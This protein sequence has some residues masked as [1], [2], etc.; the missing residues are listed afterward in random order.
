MSDALEPFTIA[1]PD[2]DLADLVERLERTRWPE[3][4]PVDDWSQG[5]PLDYMREVCA[6]WADTFDWRAVEAGLNAHP[7]FRTVIDGLG[8][9]VQHIRSPHENALP[10]VITHGWPGSI[11]E[12]QKIIGPLVDPTAHGGDAA[13]A[14]HVVLPSLPGYGW[15]DKPTTTG[16][17]VERIASAW[18]ELMTRLGYE[19]WVAQGGDWG[20][21]V[22]TQIGMQNRGGCIAI[23]TNMPVAAPDPATMD[24]LT[25]V[26]QAALEGFAHYD[27]W[28]SGYSKQQSTRPQTLGYGLVDS[29]AGQAAWILEKFWA[30]TDCDG[31]PENV[32]TRDE[33]LANVSVYWFTASAASSARLYWESFASFSEGTVDIP[34]GV[35]AFPKEIIR[36]S[37]RWA[38]QRYRDIVYWNELDRGGHF[39]AFEQPELFVEE[40][41]AFAR[42]VR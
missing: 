34:A 20:A 35:S 23:H 11:V 29:P 8:I 5:I 33:L 37:R 26:E 15:S 27:R 13:D 6:Y 28:D 31:H 19:R 38:A 22:T 25:P 42:L 2:A 17:G 36:S 30:W 24:D 32:L 16:W 7:Q 4:E 10:V 12:F 18:H 14:F 9:H 40:L 39:A 3:K 41:R 1:V 21:A